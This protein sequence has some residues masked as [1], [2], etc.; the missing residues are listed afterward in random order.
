MMCHTT[1]WPGYYFFSLV[2]EY[3]LELWLHL[4]DFGTAT[5]NR[6]NYWHHEN[7][8]VYPPHFPCILPEFGGIKRWWWVWH[9]YWRGLSWSTP[10]WTIS[11]LFIYSSLVCCSHILYMWQSHVEIKGYSV[12][13]FNYI[14]AFKVPYHWTS[15]KGRTHMRF[16]DLFDIHASTK[17]VR[18]PPLTEVQQYSTSNTA[19]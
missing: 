4:W 12:T 16:I 8:G 17:H 1:R 18:A 5:T 10:Y 14:A 19:M 13:Y 7:P 11:A 15:V 6:E 9:C 3:R 2:L